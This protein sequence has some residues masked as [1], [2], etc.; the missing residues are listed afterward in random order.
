MEGNKDSEEHHQAL[1]PRVPAPQP[2]HRGT[3]PPQSHTT[4]HQSGPAR[5]LRSFEPSLLKNSDLME[6]WV[7]HPKFPRHFWPKEGRN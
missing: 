4:I 2:T 3:D 5:S 1:G 6:L 7:L